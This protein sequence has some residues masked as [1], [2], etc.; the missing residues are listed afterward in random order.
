MSLECVYGLDHIPQAPSSPVPE[1]LVPTTT[2]EARAYRFT[3]GKHKGHT[4]STVPSS[5]LRWIIHN[6][7]NKDTTIT[8]AARFA[9][10]ILLER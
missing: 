4:A 7:N 6:S 5:Y 10:H 8:R 9:A 3:F 1:G 2:E